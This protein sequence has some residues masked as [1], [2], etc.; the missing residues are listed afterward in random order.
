MACLIAIAGRE[1]GPHSE[2]RSAR[3]LLTSMDF[4]IR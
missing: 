1:E 3:R 2:Y 4:L